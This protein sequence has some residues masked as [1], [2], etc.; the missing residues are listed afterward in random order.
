MNLSVGQLP[1]KPGL[2]SSEKQLS[3]LRLFSGTFNIVKDPLKLGSTE[4][5]V[6]EKTCFLSYHITVPFGR[7]LIAVLRR[8]PALPYDGIVNRNSRF[9]IPDHGSFPLV[10]DADGLYVFICTVDFKKGLLGNTHLSGPD[11]HGIVLYPASFRIDLSKLLL[12][13]TDHIPFFVVND[14][15]GTGGSLIKSHYVFAHLFAF[16]SIRTVP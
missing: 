7:K 16:L 5:G 1:D 10:G 3:R 2:Y 6:N 8:P 14:A 9:L 12:S 15:A 13:H 11:F 4:I